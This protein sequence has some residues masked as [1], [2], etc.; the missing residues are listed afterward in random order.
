MSTRI[1][2]TDKPTLIGERVR[3]V[4]LNSEHAVAYLASLQD[5]E[6]NRLTGSQDTFTQTQIES[7]LGSRPEQT[8]RLDLAVVEN[9][10]GKYCGEVVI[11]DVDDN[12]LSCGFRIALT[13]EF[14]GKGLG[15]EAT[16]LIVDYVFANTPMHRVGLEVYAFNPRAQ[17]VYEKVGFSKEGVMRDALRWNGEWVD[18]IMM[19]I[20]RTDGDPSS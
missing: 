7:W 12:N 2:F 8:D 20:L 3:L 19:S 6:A 10:T 4:Q 9:A 14:I 5:E 18:A 1:D 17:R 11:L 15:T 13:S 16:R